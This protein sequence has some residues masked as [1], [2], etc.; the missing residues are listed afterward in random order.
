MR[1]LSSHPTARRRDYPTVLAFWE[2]LH[3]LPLEQKRA[4]LAFTTGCDRAPVGG[5]AHLPL[6]IQRAGPDTGA[7]CS[8]PGWWL[9]AAP[10]NGQADALPRLPRPPTPRAA[11]RLPTS[12]TCFNALL[13]PEYSSA[14]RLREKLLTAISNAQGFGLQ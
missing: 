6:L 2:V 12:H 1:A 11:D 10:H 5:L 14:A 4:F 8:A 7:R 3:S 13:L 9:E